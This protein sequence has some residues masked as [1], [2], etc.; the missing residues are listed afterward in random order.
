MTEPAAVVVDRDAL[1]SALAL[2]RRFTADGSVPFS[3][4]VT[5]EQEPTGLALRTTDYH[6]HAKVLV[7]FV[8]PPEGALP[9]HLLSLTILRRMVKPIAAGH[10]GVCASDDRHVE[11]ISGGGRYSIGTVAPPKDPPPSSVPKPPPPAPPTMDA[12]GASVLH[13]MLTRAFVAA[14]EDASRPH[15]SGVLLEI[16]DGTLRVV[17]CDGHRLAV[18]ERAAAL[19][20]PSPLE[21]CYIVERWAVRGLIDWLAD[22]PAGDVEIGIGGAKD[23][24]YVHVRH[25]GADLAIRPWP[26]SFPAYRQVI[27]A[28][29]DRSIVVDGPLLGATLARLAHLTSAGRGVQIRLKVKE[30]LE[31]EIAR[32]VAAELKRTA[33]MDDTSESATETTL[34]KLQRTVETFERTSG[35]TIT[36]WRGTNIGHA[37]ELAQRLLQNQDALRPA[38]ARTEQL[39]GSLQALLVEIAALLQRPP[40]SAECPEGP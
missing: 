29:S 37:V 28:T 17:G 14:G 19:A 13:E 27:H 25:A 16:G 7:P 11:L 9:R 18:I 34:A 33:A 1:W 20:V 38:V 5:I 10:L 40:A 32:R 15:M 31:P 23:L 21:R 22:H 35:V 30:D 4:V 36:G 6:S 12:I 39:H 8:E 2:C 3:E 24:P 26:G